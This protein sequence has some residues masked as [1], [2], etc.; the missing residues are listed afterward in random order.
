[1]IGRRLYTMVIDVQLDDLQHPPLPLS[2]FYV[3]E[4]NNYAMMTS[5][6]SIRIV[7]DAGILAGW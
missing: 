5:R 6:Y 1:M 7:P 3:F 2:I 4:C